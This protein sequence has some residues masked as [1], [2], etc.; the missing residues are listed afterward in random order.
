[1]NRTSIYNLPAVQP[2]APKDSTLHMRSKLELNGIEIPALK[3][4]EH[5]TCSIRPKN[6]L[7]IPGA[8]NSPV[9][10]Q[11]KLFDHRLSQ[12]RSLQPFKR[13]LVTSA[14]PGEGK[15]FVA[16]NL[17]ITMASSSCRVLL[18]DGDM[19]RGDIG[20]RL[21]LKRKQGLIEVLEGKSNLAQSLLFVEPLNLF[22]LGS[23]EPGAKSDLLNTTAARELF[24]SLGDHFDSVI[25]DSCPVLPFSDT[26]RLAGLTDAIVVVTRE[27]V[28]RR[29][30]LEE[31]VASL[32]SHRVLGVVLNSST[33]HA[34]REYHYYKYYKVK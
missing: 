24:Q 15:T 22:F 30:E 18:V 8:G 6:R 23:G 9:L 13:I 21:G 12:F 1:M 3:D 2:S 28:S 27:N 25:V 11:L 20:H 19:R 7:V 16:V 14:V 4:I 5:V 33:E 10:E 32:S 31:A 29:S 34:E 17:A 26:H